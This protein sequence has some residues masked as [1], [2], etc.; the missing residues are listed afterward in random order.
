MPAIMREPT[1]DPAFELAVKPLVVNFIAALT[2]RI[3][4]IENRA[5]VDD[6]DGLRKASHD[7]QGM[8]GNFGF[9][10]I[11]AAAQQVEIGIVENIGRELLLLRVERLVTLCK[12][13]VRSTN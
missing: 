7:M 2:D 10:M 4:L 6:R 1:R 5:K 13:I 8:A 9:P 3:S 12:R 11:S